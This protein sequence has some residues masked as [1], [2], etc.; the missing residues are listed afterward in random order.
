MSFEGGY[1]SDIALTN[2]NAFG[3][4]IFITNIEPQ[5]SSEN[6]A[7]K[8]FSIDG[9]V[10]QSCSS[11]TNLL[12]VSILAITGFSTFKP[13]VM[14]EGLPVELIQDEDQNVWTGKID[15]DLNGKAYIEAIHNDG[16]FHRCMISSEQ[17]PVITSAIFSGNYPL[18]Q[19]ELKENDVFN[20][21]VEASIPFS[22][23]EVADYGA[24]KAQLKIVNVS[25]NA[26]ASILI[27]DRGNV[28]TNLGIKVRVINENGTKS[29][30]Y[31]TEDFGS[32]D[33]VHLLVLNN[34]SPSVTINE[35]I[36]PE[37][38]RAL[39]NNESAQL[40]S[41]VANYDT[42]VFSSP[43]EELNIEEINNYSPSKTLSR[44]GGNYNISESNISIE[45]KR[46]AN[47]AVTI[48]NGIVNISNIA[49]LITFI[50]PETRL[51][52][53][54]NMNTQ[55]QRHQLV[56]DTSQELLNSPVF[57]IPEGTLENEA[58]YN[59]ETDNYEQFVLI[60][61]NDEKGVYTAQLLI[62]TSLSGIVSTVFNND[63]QYE[64]GGFVK[65]ILQFQ[66]FTNETAIGTNVSET[67]KL[68]VSDKDEVLMH[69]SPSV[70]DSRLGFTITSPSDQ[71]N[72][73][74][75]IFHWNDVQA[76][77]NNSTGLATISIEEIP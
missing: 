45:A 54:G 63:A 58:L 36:Y 7:G 38:Q 76:V 24:S 15:I 28:A 62:A 49:P 59:N 35:I 3:G 19:T 12:S 2:S 42:I 10:L 56:I 70:I 57:T 64:I 8:V 30:W 68:V 72:P 40:K 37:N 33:K 60:H 25:T 22:T 73:K 32:T 41:S 66:E 9:S 48:A 11:S 46:S 50:A 55:V 16:A 61:D 6:V 14:V 18:D 47:G 69:Y 34:L 77:N 1:Q 17:T 4:A 31:L 23:I 52:S 65:R 51:V 74:G 27:A 44:K 20:F 67:N 71:I 29:S 21:I 5:E 43:N 13:I 26:T 75:N 53:G 39:K